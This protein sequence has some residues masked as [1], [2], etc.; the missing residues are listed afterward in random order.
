MHFLSGWTCLVIR[1]FGFRNVGDHTVESSGPSWPFPP[2]GFLAVSRA[3][4]LML[5][6]HSLFGGSFLLPL[7]LGGENLSRA[8]LQTSIPSNESWWLCQDSVFA[9]NGGGGGFGKAQIDVWAG[10]W[11]NGGLAS[12]SAYT[13]SLETGVL[14][15]FFRLL[16]AR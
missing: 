9:P 10:V 15:F 16:A 2:Q 14:F 7:K 13:K 4:Q 6:E 8:Q 5:E 11:V 3:M 1:G 12:G